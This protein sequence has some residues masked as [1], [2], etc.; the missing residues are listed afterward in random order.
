MPDDT[1]GVLYRLDIRDRDGN[2]IKGYPKIFGSDREYVQRLSYWM[3]RSYEKN[4]GLTFHG[5]GCARGAWL[6]LD[7]AEAVIGGNVN[8]S[9]T[10][11]VVDDPELPTLV[12]YEAA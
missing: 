3:G 7:G 2:S 12:F 9:S 1:P 5:D 10:P 6:S 4:L 8:H 11:P